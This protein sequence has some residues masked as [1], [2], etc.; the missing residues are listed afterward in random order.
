[1]GHQKNKKNITDLNRAE[2]RLQRKFKAYSNKN[3]RLKTQHLVCFD[4][5]TL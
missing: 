5:G 2:N 4:E 1:M 3:R